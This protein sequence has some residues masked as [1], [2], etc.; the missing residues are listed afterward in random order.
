MTAKI[1]CAG[2]AGKGQVCRFV[3]NLNLNLAAQVVR[4]KRIQRFLAPIFEHYVAFI[5]LT[6]NGEGHVEVG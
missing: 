2:V 4:T 6:L 5:H 1:F 3:I